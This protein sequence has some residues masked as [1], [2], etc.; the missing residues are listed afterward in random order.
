MSNEQIR[1]FHIDIP[2]AQLDDLHTRLD[3][4]RWPDELPGAG[5]AY[6]TSLPYLRDLTGYW[7][8]V[9]DWREQEAA[10]NELPQ[11]VT[12]IDGARVHFLHIRSPEP[13][14]VP[15][16]LTHGW[17]GSIVEFL[18]LIGPLSDPRAHGG[19]P[20]DAFH[21]VIPSVPGFGFSGP[22]REKGWHVNRWPG[23]GP[24]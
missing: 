15:L 6:G 5:W 17:P 24:S 3:L 11:F 22:T 19:D 12:E 9:Y 14:A 10:L 13:D 4:T 1:P 2:Q 16:I 18:G 7:R 8:N 20:A 21:L 23:R